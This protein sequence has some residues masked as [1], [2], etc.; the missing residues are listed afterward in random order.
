MKKIISRLIGML[1]LCLLLTPV[2][3]RAAATTAEMVQYPNVSLSPDGSKRAWTTDLWDRTDECLPLEYTIDMKVSSSLRSLNA[4]E[5]YYETEAVGSVTIGKWVVMSTPGQC[6]HDTITRDTFAGFTYRNEICQAY[7]NNGWFASCADCGKEVAHML[8]YGKESTIRQIKTVPASSV[9][10]YLCPYCTHLEQGS[11]YQHLCKGI[12]SNRYKVT[13]RPNSP[14]DS[15]VAGYMAP[16]LHMYD[17]SATYNGRPVA[18]SGYT[19]TTLRKNSF[20]C[21]GYLF[22]GWNTKPDGSGQSFTDGQAVKNLT[23][24][25]GGVVKLYAQWAK[26]ESSL[27]LD[28]AGGT[29]HGKAVYE[30]KQKFGT[31]YKV[32]NSL[33]KPPAG[34]Q[35]SF[36]TNG[37][38]KLSSMTTTKRFSHW[39]IQ[40]GFAGEFKEDVYRFTASN[41]NRDRLKAKYL[42]NGFLLPVCK[43]DNFSLVGWYDDPGLEDSGFLGKPGDEITVDK[44]TT[45]Y[46]KWATLT[47]WAYDD[48]ESHGGIGAVDLR[49]EQKDGKGKYYRLYQS[50]DQVTWNEIFEGNDIQSSINISKEYG[51][52]KQG[53]T[54][55]ISYTGNYTLTAHG[56]KGADYSN[57]CV[58][59]NGGSVSATYFLKKGDVLTVYPGTMG[60]GLSGGTNG[61]GAD[62][63]TSDSDLGRGGGAA[64][65]IYLT[66]NG[67]KTLLVTAGGGGGANAY[68]SGGPGGS[69]GGNGSTTKGADGVGSGG[70]GA[71]GGLNGAFA[72]HVH[73]QDACG[74]HEHD[75]S[76]TNE[77]D[78]YPEREILRYEDQY[79]PGGKCHTCGDTVW[80]GDGYLSY[81]ESVGH[82][83]EW[84]PLY[85]GS[86][87]IYGNYV[88]NCPYNMPEGAGGYLCGLTEELVTSASASYGGSNV[89]TSGFAGKD[90]R[91]ENGT[92][93]GA[94]KVTITSV[95]VGYTELTSLADVLAKDKAAPDR[96]SEYTTSLVDEAVCRITVTAPTDHGTL[97]YH[98]AESYEEGT[99]KKMA[100]SN[101]T[102]NTLISGVSGYRYYVDT[103]TTGTVTANHSWTSLNRVDV[104]IMAAKRYL[105]IAAVDVAGNIGLTAH[106]LIEASEIEEEYI[107]KIPPKTEQLQLADTEYVHKVSGKK[108]YVK[109]DGNTEHKLTIAGYTDGDATNQYQVDWLQ[110]VSSILSAK[111]WY[112][113]RIPKVDMQ[114]GDQ[115]FANEE[116]ETDA[117]GE[118]LNHLSPTSAV[119]ART[120]RAARVKVDQRFTIGADNDKKEILVYPRAMAEYD[121]KAYWSDQNE[122]RTHALTL[123]PDAIAPV[124]SGIEALENAG[125]I[126]MTEE[127][128]SFVIKA[129]DTGSGISSLTVIIT[130][131][132]NQ[133]QRTYSSGTGELT[134]TMKKNDFLFLGDFAVSAE[135]VDNVGNSSVLKEDSLAFTLK[136]DL[137]RAREPYDGDFKAGDGGVITVTTGGY[138]DKVIIR[139]PD[140][141]VNLDPSL[142][143]E[144]VYEFP[145][146]IKTEV[147]EFSLP[148]ETPPGSYVI[149]IEAWKNGRKLTEELQLPVRTNGSITDELRTRIRDNGV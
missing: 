122:D 40:P 56:A 90:I 117:S 32:D 20:S 60:N 75:G 92:N 78:C 125:N 121:E 5:H 3:V 50:E 141:L 57:S 41:G 11:S 12:S 7:Y 55:S 66:R 71:V 96:I 133:M 94:G 116:L 140:S 23:T 54:Y 28:A 145:T 111:E 120:N 95:D 113:T 127:S 109:A 43:K 1:A 73:T 46:A 137:K 45:L 72:Y 83:V 9:Y 130:N 70:G 53:A 77:G 27:L 118:D 123:I 31:S 38:E 105:H 24:E 147:Y 97:Y 8:I 25:D 107:E 138:A 86:I 110:M 148:L 59:G 139:F 106:I 14:N 99:A 49:W 119:A 39:E 132:D 126:D 100:T 79:E 88:F 16:T 36:E 98:M 19:D 48:Y 47:L 131:L 21:V 136:A 51:T 44:D 22:Q 18:E 42:N 10:V 26:A 63:G 69:D 146:A 135:A 144:Y 91:L 124:I 33:V 58:G 80:Q 52:D 2:T 81:H 87:P 6:I 4:G 114:S 108:Y 101:I 142:D 115:E 102:T 93:D 128:K 15:D 67:T 112:Q 30:Q 17:N 129:S 74:Y 65:Q 64:T 84:I 29:Y 13:Y 62:G 104:E 103:H 76:A 35:V 89:A 61:N 82:D 85:V 37:G 68:A 134:I 34:Y 143:R 149:E